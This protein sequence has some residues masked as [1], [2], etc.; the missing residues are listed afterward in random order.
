MSKKKLAF[1]LVAYAIIITSAFFV[2]CKTLL[3]W[4][5]LGWFTVGINDCFI[6]GLLNENKKL[7]G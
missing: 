6:Y 4:S 7:K 3:L 1:K 2:D 5:V